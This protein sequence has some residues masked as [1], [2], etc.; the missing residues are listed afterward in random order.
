MELAVGDG[1]GSV[2][3][4]VLGFD[5]RF[6]AR[7]A[8]RVYTR[9]GLSRLVLVRPKPIDE[10]SEKKMKEALDYLD[11]LA[12][13][14]LQVEIE[15]VDVDHGNFRAVYLAGRKTLLEALE[16][17]DRV[18][19]CLSG[20]MRYAGAALL[21]AAFTL[22]VESRIERLLDNVSVQIDLESGTGFIELSLK[23]LR[24]LA[25][26]TVYDYRVLEHL[27]KL[28][29]PKRLTDIADALEMPKSTTWKILQRLVRAGIVEEK[30]R[31]YKALFPP[32]KPSS[33]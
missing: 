33:S 11:K 20:G 12:R 14:Y 6:L 19:V 7:C 31:R 16:K 5:E 2:L 13:E 1:K 25:R 3:I 22:P 15:L 24:E 23:P 9:T 18:V 26:L 8:M 4:G 27:W 30:N 28:E 29:E 17:G 32:E 21:S 10:Y